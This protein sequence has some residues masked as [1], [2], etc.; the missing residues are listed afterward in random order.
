MID[1]LNCYY[2]TGDVKA[3]YATC[4]TIFDGLP[5]VSEFMQFGYSLH[6]Y[7]QMMFVQ[8]EHVIPPFHYQRGGYKI[9]YG[10]KASLWDGKRYDVPAEAIVHLHDYPSMHRTKQHNNHQFEGE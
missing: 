4:S 7:S 3:E 6:F 8:K 5:A 10:T 1:W 9:P 2:V